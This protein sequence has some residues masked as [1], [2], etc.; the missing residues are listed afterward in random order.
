MVTYNT[1][2]DV[3]GKM[4]NWQDAVRVLDEMTDQVIAAPA[5]LSDAC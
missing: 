1:L 4:G 5:A 3:Y 2:I